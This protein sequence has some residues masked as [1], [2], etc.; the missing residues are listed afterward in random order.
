MIKHTTILNV[1]QIHCVIAMNTSRIE[2]LAPLR[3][4]PRPRRP[5]EVGAADILRM[6][7]AHKL[8]S[9]KEE[10][11]LLLLLSSTVDFDAQCATS[12]TTQIQ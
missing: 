3:P 5:H 7:S 10:S 4:C 12:A 2:W 6:A 9:L 8:D 1:N 11:V